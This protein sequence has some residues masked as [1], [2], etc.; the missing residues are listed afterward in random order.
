VYKQ[1]FLVFLLH[2]LLYTVSILCQLFACMLLIHMFLLYTAG[3]NPI[4]RNNSWLMN[5]NHIPMDKR[6]KHHSL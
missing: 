6:Y 5:Y 3:R 2:T 4:A 1:L